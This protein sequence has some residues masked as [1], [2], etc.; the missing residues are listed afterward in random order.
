[1]TL[2]ED[3]IVT[4]NVFSFSPAASVE[5]AAGVGQRPGVP[6]QCGGQDETHLRGQDHG[7]HG[8]TEGFRESAGGAV[9]GGAGERVKAPV[10][11]L[12]LVYNMTVGS[13]I[14]FCLTWV[15]T[16][17]S[18][19]SIYEHLL[20]EESYKTNEQRGGTGGS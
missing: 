7:R 17:S 20:F 6:L 14:W 12:S 10:P 4:W 11:V 16:L 2:L 9:R 5:G 8:E 1:V 3:D 15:R 13:T 19:S 18:D